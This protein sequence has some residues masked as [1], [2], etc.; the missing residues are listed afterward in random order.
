MI[1]GFIG[2]Y[3]GA[4]W[5]VRSIYN[6][7]NRVLALPRY[8]WRDGKLLTIKEPE[9]SI[10]IAEL[11]GEDIVSYSECFGRRVPLLKKE[12]FE[13]V[14]DPR[15]GPFNLRGRVGGVA[16]ELVELLRNET[17]SENVGITGGLLLGKQT[18]DIDLIIYGKDTCETAYEM[19]KKGQILKSYSKSEAFELILRRGQKLITEELIDKEARKSLQGKFR[20]FDVYIRLVP[21]LPNSPVECKRR[22]FKVGGVWRY[23]E[24]TDSSMGYLYPCTY[25]ALDLTSGEEIVIFS[26]RGR[27]CELLDDGEKAYVKGEMEIIYDGSQKKLAI[28]LWSQEHYLLPS[29]TLRWMK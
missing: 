9:E 23:V 1:E 16:V 3:G 18:E 24:V 6:V 22:V 4:Y 8:V 26:D 12:S 2:R 15:F 14:L 13:E 11:A 28:N 10:E 5:I 7:D 29:N 25:S 20:G 27:Y 17:G 21:V 19:L